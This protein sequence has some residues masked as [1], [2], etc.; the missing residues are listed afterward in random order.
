MEF[1]SHHK[2]E[3]C[4]FHNSTWNVFC[5][6]YGPAERVSSIW[7]KFQYQNMKSIIEKIS[8]ER[9]VLELVDDLRL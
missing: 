8:Y 1:T 6:P 3:F 4:A 2:L 9:H 7:L 5:L